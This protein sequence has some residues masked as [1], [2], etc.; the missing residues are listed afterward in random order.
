MI[1][2]TKTLRCLLLACVFYLLHFC[3]EAQN[4]SIPKKLESDTI[5]KKSQSDT[6]TRKSLDEYLRTRKGFFGKMFKGLTR[7]TTPVQKANDLRRNDAPYKLFEGA[8]IRNIIIKDLPFGIPLTDTSKKVVTVFTE[9]AN[10]LHHTTRKA[11]IR[12]NL[13]FRENELL[14][15]YLMADN[16]T[17]LRQLP[18]IQDAVIELEP[19]HELSLDSVDVYVVVKD[20]FSL[21][22]SISSLGL[23]NT[24]VAIK[25]DNITGSGNGIVIHGLYDISRRR[26]FGAGIEYVLR[27]IGN[28]FINFN[29]GYQS[30]YPNIIGLKE[31]NLYYMKL[32]K[33][34]IN[35]YAHWTYEFDGSYHSTRNMYSSDSIYLSDVRYRYYNADAWAGYNINSTGFTTKAEDKKLRK[36]IGLR[37]IDQQFQDLPGKYITQYDWRYANLTAAIA[38]FSFYRQNFYKSQYIY[39]FGINEDIPEGLNL[40][41]T[42]GY[43]K[44]QNLSRPFMGF[45][46]ERSIFNRKNNYFSYTIRAE[47]YLDHK[48]FE[49]INLFGT[50][51]YFDHLK[52]MGKKWKQRTFVDI[53]VAKQINTILNEPLYIDSKYG[54]PAFRGGPDG[55][56]LRTS[57]KAESVF[58]S[59]WA[60]ESFRF[61]PFVF[62]Y[63][64][65]FTPYN[66]P[67]N[68]SNIYTIVGGGLRTRNE[69]L[70]FGTLELKG[71]YF[72]K[73][74]INNENWRVDIS[75]D[76]TFKY[77]TQ[78]VRKP[79][80]IQVN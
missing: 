13:F 50:I 57:V 68:T 74:N 31:E 78:L 16:E 43:T 11:V 38:S 47:G 34:L 52:A 76:I 63:S 22:G 35:R 1:C 71:Y 19:S 72:L 10:T 55:G 41:L 20:L 26:N 37:V 2:S 46:Y 67:I 33:P 27:N 28:S 12:N 58:Y 25:E 45:N 51:D 61:A 40:T 6:I 60:L 7:D 14:V 17:Y 80:F 21:G 39:A 32:T 62:A 3:A 66:T 53:G 54:L 30:Y 77:N 24:D 36:L 48:K 8:V 44:K 56:S 73:K 9:V 75:T 69:S 59:P 42:A 29:F 70:I 23:K 18:Y 15:P 65:L 79:D 5:T 49:D 4:D 64:G